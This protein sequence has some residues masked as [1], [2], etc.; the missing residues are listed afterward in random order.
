MI[1]AWE[2]KKLGDICQVIAGQSPQGKYY[3]DAGFGLP[4]YQGKR[5]FKSK[6]IGE[7]TTWTTSTTKEAYPGDILISVRAPVGP[8]NFTDKHICIGRG[9]AAI[10]PSKLMDN[11]FLFYFLLKHENELDVNIGAVFSSINKTQIENIEIPCPSLKEQKRIVSILNKA[12]VAID[13]IKTNT[14]Q[15]LK[16]VKD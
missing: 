1:K 2:I 7:P 9:L 15:N 13:K 6:Y 16:N 14:E 11:E 10:R 3:N 5:E 8:V 4:F 12:F